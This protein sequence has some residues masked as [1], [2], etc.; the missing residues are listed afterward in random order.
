M[1]TIAFGILLGFF[2]IMTWQFILTLVIIAVVGIWTLIAEILKSI[3]NIFN[4]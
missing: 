3:K 4:K 1:W 2:L